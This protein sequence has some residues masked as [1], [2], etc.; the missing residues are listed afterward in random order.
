MTTLV[1][2]M[3]ANKSDV[4]TVSPDDTV[5]DALRVMADHNIGAVLV[6]NDDALAG[7]LSE[8]D[9]A[10]KMVL[11]GKASR[12][13]LVGEVMT[14]HVVSVTPAW[15]CDQCMSLMTERHVRHLP[16]VQ[17]GRVVG[18]ISIGDVVRAVLGEHKTTITTLEHYIMSGG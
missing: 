2:H 8:R 14:S 16:V 5:L 13:T 15:S 1:R 11:H 6:M 10:R 18:V 3:L 17:D 12:D 9:Y 7:I 4:H